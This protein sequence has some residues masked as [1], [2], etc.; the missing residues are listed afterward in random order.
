M[1]KLF[2][3]CLAALA[4]GACKSQ[5][6]TTVGTN[7]EGDRVVRQELATSGID[8]VKVLNEDGTGMV[9]RPY[10]WYAGFSSM[11]SKAH[12]IKYAEM[13]ARNRVANII[14]SIVQEQIEGGALANNGKVQEAIRNHWQQLGQS[15]STGLEPYGNAIVEY[16]AT[17]QMY[18]VTVKLGVS[19]ERFQA[20]LRKAGNFKPSDLQGEELQ[21]FIDVNNSII[22]AAKTK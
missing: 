16:N 21:Q 7:M 1:K 18:D 8:M 6:Q 5:K 11:N 13:D 4:L 10:K 19:G 14:Q 9:E 12:A 15:I 17:T 22:E 3:F 20:M 2:I